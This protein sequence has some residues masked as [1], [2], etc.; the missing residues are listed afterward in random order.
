MTTSVLYDFVL[1][2]L[3]DALAKRLFPDSLHPNY[4]TLAG[5]MCTVLSVVAMRHNSL[6][7]A[8]AFFYSYTALDNMDG[9]HARRTGQCSEF[10]SI[11]D[12]AID[13]SVGLF[14][15]LETAAHVLIGTPEALYWDLYHSFTV[16]YL[17]PHVVALYSS[18]L[19]LGCAAA[20]VDE[21]FLLVVLVLGLG[22]TY[23]APLVG[24]TQALVAGVG[25]GGRLWGEALRDVL[26]VISAAWVVLG[27]VYH[28]APRSSPMASPM[29]SPHRRGR[30]AL[31]V[32]YVAF[33]LAPIVTGAEAAQRYVWTPLMLATIAYPMLTKRE[34]EAPKKG[35]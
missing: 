31:V 28:A 9:K 23:G 30:F 16:T 6:A 2:P 19:D 24:N 18:R 13:G 21:A 20:S 12:H 15:M 22:A 3:Y 25:W 4:I 5:G 7:C 14:S 29:A 33:W 10:G 32:A 8:S 26:Y 35:E 17:A 27:V 34:G 11:L 1:S